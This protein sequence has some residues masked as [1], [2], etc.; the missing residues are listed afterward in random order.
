MLKAMA[1][2]LPAAVRNTLRSAYHRHQ[3]ASGTFRSLEPEWGRLAEWLG[4]G[5]TAIDIGANIGHYTARMSELVGQT[6]RVI[7]VEPVPQT[8]A[9]LAANVRS[10]RFPNVTLLNLAS[11]EEYALC[12]LTVPTWPDG[13]PNGYLARVDPQGRLQ[14]LAIPLDALGLSGP[15]RLAKID[16]EGYEAPVLAGMRDLL[17][18]HRPVV[19][20]ERNAE[21]EPLLESLGYQISVPA[22]RSP[23]VIALP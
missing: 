23:N 6:G 21:A 15:V 7:A 16:T 5:D 12:S 3:I 11:G 19:I 18:R 2:Y 8:F 22:V 4:P 10:F 9:A 20:L 17:G 14:V 13:T 1:R